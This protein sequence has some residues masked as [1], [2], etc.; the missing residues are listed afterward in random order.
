MFAGRLFL[1]RGKSFWVAIVLALAWLNGLPS[2]AAHFQGKNVAAATR[3]R[4]AT[5]TASLSYL[6]IYVALQK[7]FFAKRG[8]DMEVIQMAAG[9]A[10]PALL[11]RAIDYTTIPSGPATAGARGAPLKVIC[12][13]S[14]KL[15]HVLIS[16]PEITTVADLAG[17]RIGAGSFGTLPA[18]EVRV[19][20]E[21]YRLGANTI[22][23]PLN[24]TNDRMIGTQRG[25]I[26]AT[27]VPAPFDLKA[28]EMGLRRLLH[29]GT[30][31]PIPQAGLATTDEKI[32]TARQE[33][34][35]ILKATIEGL[36][37]TWSQREGTLEI[38]AKWMNLKP[39]QA[40][41]VYDS[42]RETFS[43]NGVPTE[44]QAKAYITMLGST[45]GLK[46]DL[47]AAAIFDFSLAAEAARELAVKK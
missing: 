44:E 3:I 35:E 8:F 37:Y 46:G 14:V 43:K 47:P 16:R 27:V 5:P 28:E 36:D 32:K 21:R 18:Y 38:I 15:Q 42:V 20:I 12:F 24:S 22:I 13:T 7:G 19:L 39:A 29:M 17:K 6:P 2:K 31:L 9:L 11:N 26:D 45:A 41:I 30:I 10:A 40:A 33:I 1:K 25:T 34:V 4:L 23:V